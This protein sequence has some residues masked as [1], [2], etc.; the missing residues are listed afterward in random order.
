MNNLNSLFK[1][2]L[3]EQQ[4]DGKD[5]YWSQLEQK[6]NDNAQEKVVIAWY[7]KWLLPFFFF[8]FVGVSA[9]IYSNS[10]SKKLIFNKVSFIN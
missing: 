7:K 2:K 6:L 10:T 4:F 1:K 9:L 5:K 8:F 3:A